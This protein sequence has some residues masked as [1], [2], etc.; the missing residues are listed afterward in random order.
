MT[1]LQ[2]AGDHLGEGL[3]DAALKRRSTGR[4]ELELHALYSSQSWTLIHVHGQRPEARQGESCGR[5]R[6]ARVR[7]VGSERGRA[8]ADLIQGA[9]VAAGR[10][11]TQASV[12]TPPSHDGAWPT[13]RLSPNSEQQ[14]RKAFGENVRQLPGAWNV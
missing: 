10:W 13:A 6:R 3:A 2:T 7:A 11:A 4:R 14:P 5:T 12:L 9:A 1:R 8:C